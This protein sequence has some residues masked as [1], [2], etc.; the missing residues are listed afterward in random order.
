MFT[1]HLYWFI[2]RRRNKVLITL[3]SIFCI[4]FFLYGNEQQVKS[5]SQKSTRSVIK[6]IPRKKVRVNRNTYTTP[7]PCHGCP[8]ENGAGVQLTVIYRN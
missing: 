4:L 3:I 7:E 5:E 8:G 1:S 6:H 2:Y